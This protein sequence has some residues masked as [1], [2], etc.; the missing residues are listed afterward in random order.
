LGLLD[1]TDREAA[2]RRSYQTRV[3]K[4]TANGL[5]GALAFYATIVAA[6][7]DSGEEPG[8]KDRARPKP[9]SQVLKLSVETSPGIVEFD[10]KRLSARAGRIAFELTNP[11]QKGH[12]LRIHT[13]DT[14][15]FQP[16][17][18]D[19]GGTATID[20]GRARVVLDLKP[21]TYTYLCSAGGYWRTQ[22]GRL[23]VR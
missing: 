10:T 21:G 4:L 9:V 17:S 3:G 15:C 2:A 6:C 22:H 16:G 18:R 1:G 13:G 7:G 8:V 11:K 5:S 20:T 14:C 19:I 12:N 23:V